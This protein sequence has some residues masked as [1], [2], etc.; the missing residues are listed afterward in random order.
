MVS[1]NTVDHHVSTVLGKLGVR[2]RR[3]AGRQALVL[4][5]RDRDGDVAK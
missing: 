4:G 5:L 3:V 2:N 1:P